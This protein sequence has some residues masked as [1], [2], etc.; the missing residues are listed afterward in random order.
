M[1]AD[2]SE[3]DLDFSKWVSHSKRYAD[4][5]QKFTE[6]GL[7]NSVGHKPGRFLYCESLLLG[8]GLTSKVY[9]GVRE[10]DGMEIALKYYDSKNPIAMQAFEHEVAMFKER[11]SAQGIVHYFDCVSQDLDIQIMIK[12]TIIKKEKMHI[13]CIALE[14]MEFS[15]VQ[16]V[17]NW[18]TTPDRFGCRAHI[19]ACQYIGGSVLHT[20]REL[21]RNIGNSYH[22]HRDVKPGNIQFDILDQVRLIDFG[23][24]NR[25]AWDK[26]SKTTVIK[27]TPNY[28]APEV[29]EGRVDIHSDLFS[30]G[31][32]LFYMATGC[33]RWDSS[34][35]DVKNL[36]Q[37]V[38]EKWK[39]HPHRAATLN[40]LLGALWITDP[41]KRA[42]E[43]ADFH[44]CCHVLL[45]HPFFWTDRVATNFLVELGNLAKFEDDEDLEGMKSKIENIVR[46]AG[47]QTWKEMVDPGLLTRWTNANPRRI[48][49]HKP[50]SLLKFI[51][52]L[53]NHPDP[54][55]DLL[56]RQPYFLLQFPTLLCD[57][58]EVV[59]RDNH[60][61]QRHQMQ[62]YLQL[63]Y[64]PNIDVEPDLVEMWV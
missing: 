37:Q 54:D 14:L 38:L 6:G 59:L 11:N 3:K 57:L 35:L 48:N 46:A 18:N 31:L 63:T 8:E 45:R 36:Q 42:F 43:T 41:K 5:I 16:L 30:F 44:K 55:R 49:D 15:L 7:A 32:V 47:K 61:S 24:S 53:Y 13:R 22:I 23:F 17:E 9:I 29:Q 19:M 40:H 60:L 34:K 62:V 4:V 58:W 1:D 39:N 52:D 51:R 20:L 21:R 56:T 2:E 50:L 26:S 33:E 27:C 28:A 64:V 25:L 12:P 10:S